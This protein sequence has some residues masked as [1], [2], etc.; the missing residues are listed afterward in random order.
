MKYHSD[1]SDSSIPKII[2][3]KIRKDKIGN[4]NIYNTNSNKISENQSSKIR[5]TKNSKDNIKF[6]SISSKKSNEW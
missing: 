3:N 5:N 6:S 4:K 1:E 2:N